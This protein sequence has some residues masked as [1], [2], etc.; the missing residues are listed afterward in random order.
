MKIKPLASVF[1]A[2]ATASCLSATISEQSFFFEDPPAR[3]VAGVLPIAAERITVRSSCAPVE[4]LRFAG[5]GDAT[6]LYFGGNVF[7]LRGLAERARRET[8]SEASLI[9][10]DYPGRGMST[11]PATPECTLAAGVAVGA[12][13]AEHSVGPVVYHGFSFGGFVAAHTAQRMSAD[14]APSAVILEST[15]VDVGSWAADVAG[16]SGL[17]SIHL[18]ASLNAFNNVR[19]LSTFNGPIWVVAARQDRSVPISQAEKL[20]D[21]LRLAGR[22]VQL[23]VFSGAHGSALA[24]GEALDAYRRLLAAQ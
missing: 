13:A 3:R 8:P 19:A 4:V 6:V 2:L 14:K 20:R 1:A 22:D 18:P 24:S 11:G 10:F 12:W 15:A 9:V 17:V 5:T 16:P 21:Q 23:D 7:R